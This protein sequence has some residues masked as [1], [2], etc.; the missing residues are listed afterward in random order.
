MGIKERVNE[1]QNVC[2]A[3]KRLLFARP[4]GYDLQTQNAYT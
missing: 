2:T 1:Q 4:D 3:K